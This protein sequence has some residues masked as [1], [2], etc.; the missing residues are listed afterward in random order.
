L[1]CK[2]NFAIQH[3]QSQHQL[4]A[5]GDIAQLSSSVIVSIVLVVVD[6]IVAVVVVVVAA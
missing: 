3:S 1:F 6:I 2:S 5:S 4:A